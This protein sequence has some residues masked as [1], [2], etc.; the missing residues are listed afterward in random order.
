MADNE[1]KV[2]S[3]KANET[4]SEESKA[5][6]KVAKAAKGNSKKSDKP[7][8]FS[9]MAKGS[10][11]FFKDFKGESKKIV[12]PDARTV[13]KSTG[14]V[15]LVVAIV[16]LIIWGIDSGLTAGISGL[17][18]LAIGETETTVSETVD[19]HEGHDHDEEAEETTKADEK[20]EEAKDETTVAEKAE[21]EETTAKAE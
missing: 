15:I 19:E 21:A 16:A 1:K 13:L 20:K 11:K 2:S 7:N 18:H 10:K 14:I 8:V 6:E 3:S 9:R 12:W 4:V 5:A 17:K